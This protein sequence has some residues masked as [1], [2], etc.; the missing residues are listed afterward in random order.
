[1]TE[2]QTNSKSIIVYHALLGQVLAHA[3]PQSDADTQ[4]VQELFLACETARAF[5]ATVVADCRDLLRLE[6]LLTDDRTIIGVL[7]DVRRE[8]ER[9]LAERQAAL[10]AELDAANARPNS[11]PD[12]TSSPTIT[13][14]TDRN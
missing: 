4:F 11:R 1:M 13:K 6:T 9:Q 3:A 12:L 10:R 7:Q 5:N 8:Q 2:S 14:D